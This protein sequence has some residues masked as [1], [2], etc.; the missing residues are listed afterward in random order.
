[1]TRTI[2]TFADH[3]TH[4]HV[5]DHK[6]VWFTPVAVRQ[7]GSEYLATTVD[8]AVQS[9][10]QLYTHASKDAKDHKTRNPFSSVYGVMDGINSV[11]GTRT[12]LSEPSSTNL[13][14]MYRPHY[15]SKAHL[16][17]LEFGIRVLR[18][19]AEAL[20]FMHK[21]RDTSRSPMFHGDLRPQSVL[22]HDQ[23]VTLCDN[24]AMRWPMHASNYSPPERFRSSK[25]CDGFAADVYAFGGIIFFIL[26]GQHPWQD[27]NVS[28]VLDHLDNGLDPLQ[29]FQSTV[30]TST[31]GIELVKPTQDPAPKKDSF[32]KDVPPVL[33]LVMRG[34]FGIKSNHRLT[35]EEIV[36]QLRQCLPPKPLATIDIV[37]SSV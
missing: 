34:C 23:C 10:R 32:F 8:A 28:D 31:K 21:P 18:E 11:R 4:G 17:S 7:L 36:V 24:V 5:R 14:S 20:L 37:C 22:L 12:I 3:L 30:E 33:M 29:A 26:T 1:M 35:M 19:L 9:W 16:V 15:E 13:Q 27:L 2:T 25:P 6:N